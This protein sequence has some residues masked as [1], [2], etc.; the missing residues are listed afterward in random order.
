MRVHCAD[1]YVC[2]CRG[3]WGRGQEGVGGGGQ[4][5]TSSLDKM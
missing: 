1:M 4:C 2:V 5:N 3:G